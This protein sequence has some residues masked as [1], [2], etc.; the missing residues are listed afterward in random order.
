MRRFIRHPADVPIQYEL[1][2]KLDIDHKPL[3]N[4]SEGGLCFTTDE[5]I[6]P[7]LEIHLGIPTGSAVFETRGTVVWCKPVG[8][9]YEVGVKFREEVKAFAARIAE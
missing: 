6:E 3:K 4:Y 1:Q 8:G 2:G 7:D 9:N 5:W